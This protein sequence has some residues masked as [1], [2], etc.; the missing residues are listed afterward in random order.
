MK[1]QAHRQRRGRN[2]G[3]AGQGGFTL[4]EVTIMLLILGAALVMLSG[5]Q[6]T[7]I[8]STGI[9]FRQSVAVSL[10]EQRLEELRGLTYTDT[11]TDAALTAGAHA[12]ADI[13]M[14][15]GVD[16]TVV[17]NA[18]GMTYSRTYTVADNDPTAD[19]KLITYNMTWND[20]IAHTLTMATRVG[21]N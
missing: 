21:K 1:T 11:I 9:G 16:V 15:N 17:P 18:H 14:L 3:M 12:D 20:G 13:V 6:T 5:V 4:L 2:T 19:V 7:S 8:R 10:M